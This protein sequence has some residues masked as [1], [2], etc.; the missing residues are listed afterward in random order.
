MQA[1]CFAHLILYAL[2]V[3]IFGEDDKL[4]SSSYALFS[5]LLLGPNILLS[6]LFSHIL[7]LSSFLDV[8]DQVSRP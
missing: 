2:Y 1:T 5:N 8:T 6:T 7:N 3:L 4:W